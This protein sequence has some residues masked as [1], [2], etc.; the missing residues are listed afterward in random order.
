M[1]VGPGVQ[2]KAVEGDAL[3]ADRD[4]SQVRAHLGVEPIAVHAKVAGRIAQPNDA[5]QYH[6]PS[7]AG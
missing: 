6:R 3:R 7:S 1:L 5:G 2:V 4:L